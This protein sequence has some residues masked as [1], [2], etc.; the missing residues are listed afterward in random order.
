MVSDSLEVVL[1]RHEYLNICLTD[2]KILLR[3][4]RGIVFLFADVNRKAFIYLRVCEINVM[5]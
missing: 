2:I 3:V 5:T 1:S 4:K